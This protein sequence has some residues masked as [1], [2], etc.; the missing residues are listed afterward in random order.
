MVN[1]IAREQREADVL[2]TYLG[3]QVGFK[4]ALDPTGRPSWRPSMAPMIAPQ[5]RQDSISY[6]YLP[7]E[8]DI[9]TAF[10]TFIKGCGI[11]D[12]L[13]VTDVA[14]S[15]Y[16]YSQ[17]IDL[18]Y[19]QRAYVAAKQNA[20][21]SIAAAPS[22]FWNGSLGFYMRAGAYI[23]KWDLASLSWVLKDDASADSVAY[24]DLMEMN[25]K[26]Y[27]PRGNTVD[28]KYSTDG[29]TW[30]AFTD[31]DNNFFK[32]VVRGIASGAAV[33]WG[34]KNG[35]LNGSLKNTTNGANGGVAWSAG[36]QV[37]HTSETV[38]SL[39][40]LDDSMF[41]FTTGGIY[42]YTGTVQES[43]WTGGRKML[44]ATNGV[45]AFLWDDGMIYVPYG[46]RLLQANLLGSQLNPPK[47][48]FVFPTG[49]QLG[50]SQI[51][52]SITAI[53]GDANWLY[54]AIKNVA[55]DTYIMRGKPSDGI[56]HTWL[57]LGANDCNALEIV[58][59]A[60]GVTSNPALFFGYGTT[61]RYAIL[62]RANARPEDDTNYR[63]DTATGT[64]YGPWMTVGT[65]QFKKLLNG[66]RLI[67][68]N[69]SAGKPITLSYE[70]D[71]SGTAVSMVDAV[72][73]GVTATNTSGE[74]AYRRVRYVI[75]MLTAD[76]ST[77]P[78]LLGALLHSV[79]MSPRK[80]MWEF[81]VELSPVMS[82]RGGSRW[83]RREQE[84][85]LF[86]MDE[87]LVTLYD[88]VGRT[89]DTRLITVGASAGLLDSPRG[90]IETY[91][92][93]LAEIAE[94][95]EQSTSDLLVLDQDA[96]DAGKVWG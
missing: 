37:A 3:N 16:N 26:M 69:V 43:V 15:V 23:Y 92:V 4:L 47:L 75:T 41:V 95:T 30:T 39:I 81:D 24:T 44:T 62:P 68:E 50:N 12:I 46:D 63:F 72:S 21:S 79:L 86:A 52:G 33:L 38:G 83:D 80:R 1:P 56:W 55:G 13:D 25:G 36:D 22:G 85:F 73:D 35:T 93:V 58:G 19:P 65:K 78:R 17:G 71:N 28:Y 6:A 49:D 53:T 91:H 29:T 76:A 14:P 90:D 67:C 61:C 5:V 89:F 11:T 34:L 18:S 40:E 64:V 51:N 54:V 60:V 57:Y 7:P 32:F 70:I 82:V 77:S 45:G 48:E 66:G 20:T 27:A 94:T 2:L 84:R 87:G 9:V 96:Y 88:R 42:R 74:I 8:I 59:A 31:S 10:E